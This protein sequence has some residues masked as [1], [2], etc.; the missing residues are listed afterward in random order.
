VDKNQCVTILTKAVGP[1]YGVVFFEH[2]GKSGDLEIS[3]EFD[4]LRMID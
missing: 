1:P 4:N 2:V 3:F